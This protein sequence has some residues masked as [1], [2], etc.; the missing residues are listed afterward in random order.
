M[1]DLMIRQD[2]QGW[3][4]TDGWIC[5]KCVNDYALKKAIDKGAVSAEQCDFCKSSP[6]A[7]LDS[8]LAAFVSGLHTEYGDADNEGVAWDGREGGYQWGAK[9]D[10]WD[11]IDGFDD[12]LTGDGLLDAVRNA[13]HDRVWVE[14]NFAHPREDEALSWS[15]GGVTV[16]NP[17]GP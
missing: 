7:P 2:E 6:A 1:K 17:N 12:V 10:T 13:I 14:V 15:C 9:W 16:L 11:L 5:G 8:L 3:D 4:F